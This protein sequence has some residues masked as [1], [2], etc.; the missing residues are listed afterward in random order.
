M[1]RVLKMSLKYGAI[2]L[3]YTFS[4]ILDSAA[5]IQTG[6]QFYLQGMSDFLYCA[7]TLAI[8]YMSGNFHS[9]IQ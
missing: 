8:F 7:E 3:Q 2:W 4:K 5:R 1:T 6:R 9:E